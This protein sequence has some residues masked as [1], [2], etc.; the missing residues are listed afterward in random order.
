MEYLLKKISSPIKL[1][2]CAHFYSVV[3]PFKKKYK[4]ERRE[5]ERK[6]G[7]CKCGKD[8]ISGVI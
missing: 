5:N 3:M 2:R 7:G 6:R 8:L 1:R 4:I